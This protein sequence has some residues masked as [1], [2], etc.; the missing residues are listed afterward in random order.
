MRKEDERENVLQYLHQIE[1]LVNSPTSSITCNLHSLSCGPATYYLLAV[2]LSLNNNNNNNTLNN[3]DNNI[4]KAS[5][6]LDICLKA[7][8]DYYPAIFL[9][10]IT[11]FLLFVLL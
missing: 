7:K 2:A 6:Y 11:L 9:K 8:H 4:N 1:K 5:E 3:N 10:G